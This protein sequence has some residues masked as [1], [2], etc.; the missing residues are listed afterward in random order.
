MEEILT[1]QEVA[2]RLKLKASWVYTHADDLGALRLGKYVRFSWPRVIERLER[3]AA[4]LSALGPK[5][6]DLGQVTQ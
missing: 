2:E 3:G 5:P 1:V 4:E 6:K